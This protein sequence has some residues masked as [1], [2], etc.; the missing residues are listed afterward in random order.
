MT[1]AGSVGSAYGPISVTVS[2]L[3]HRK[4]RSWQSQ[5]ILLFLG[6][7]L[8]DLALGGAVNAQ[9]RH[10]GLPAEIPLQW[11]VCLL[12]RGPENQ[13]FIFEA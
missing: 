11:G 6:E 4:N 2:G 5:Q 9:V 7:E 1:V 8:G 10:R 13:G 3:E 12:V